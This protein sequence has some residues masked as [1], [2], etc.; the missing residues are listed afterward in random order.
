MMGA[1]SVDASADTSGT[2]RQKPPETAHGVPDEC[3]PITLRLEGACVWYPGIGQS[4]E[5]PPPVAPPTLFQ[6]LRAVT[7]PDFGVRT[8]PTLVTYA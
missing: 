5:I 1:E 7:P 6:A 8:P 2:S 3:L 4:A